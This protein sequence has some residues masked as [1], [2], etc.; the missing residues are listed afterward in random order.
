MVLASLLMMSAT[1][2]VA[3]AR[4]I[5]TFMLDYMGLYVRMSLQIGVYSGSGMC[6]GCRQLGGGCG[7]HCGELC[8]AEMWPQLLLTGLLIG[9]RSATSKV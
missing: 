8:Q 4:R 7:V 1:A 3:S 6:N 9:R 2:A 5:V